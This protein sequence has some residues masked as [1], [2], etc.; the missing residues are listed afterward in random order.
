MLL[1][2][3]TKKESPDLFPWKKWSSWLWKW[4][5]YVNF[6]GDN[7]IYRASLLLINSYDYLQIYLS[8]TP[9]WCL[10]LR[11]HILYLPQPQVA[12]GENLCG[13][14][15]VFTCKISSSSIKKT[16]FC[17]FTNFLKCHTPLVPHPPGAPPTGYQ[18]RKS[19]SISM[20]KMEFLA[21][22]MT[23]LCQF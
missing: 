22:K 3:G 15:N 13:S 4:L 7:Q 19:R 8:A 2:Q 20:K 16:K 14:Q 18:E 12:E 21:L 1:Q 9:S 23:E 5:S 11:C 10:T 17:L 6:S